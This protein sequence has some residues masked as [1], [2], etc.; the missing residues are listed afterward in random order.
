MSTQNSPH[1]GPITWTLLAVVELFRITQM[2]LVYQK[3]GLLCITGLLR[4]FYP[5]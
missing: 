1:D 5:K 2:P 4:R 3:T